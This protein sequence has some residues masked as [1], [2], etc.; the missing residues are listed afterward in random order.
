MI[1][2]YWTPLIYLLGDDSLVYPY[3]EKYDFIES[4]K[5]KEIAMTL[6]EEGDD[7]IQSDVNGSYTGM[8]NDGEVPV[9]DADDL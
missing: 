7:E 8:T 1:S 2:Y 4:E 9:Q 3:N 6:R 5:V